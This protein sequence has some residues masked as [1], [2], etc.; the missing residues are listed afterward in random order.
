[1][2]FIDDVE[3]IL[4]YTNKEKR[5]MLFC[6]TMPERILRLAKDYMRGYQF[7]RAQKEQLTVSLTDQ[8]YFEV[9]QSDK[10][11]AL[12]RIIDSEVDF[13]GLIFCRTKIDVDSLSK[14]LS[15]RGYDAE[16]LHGDIS[17]YQ[18]ERILEKFKQQRINVLVA[19][20]VA[21]RGIDI[22]NLSHVINFSLPQDPESYVHRIGRTGRAGKEGTAITFV[23]PYEYRK[24][25]AIKRLT[26][27]DIRKEKIPAIEDIIR[28]KKTRI[29]NDIDAIIRSSAEGQYLDFA[30]EILTEVEPEKALAAIIKHAFGD[31]LSARSYSKIRDVSIDMKG[32]TRLFVARGRTDGMDPRKL[33]NML[34]QTAQVNPQKIRDVRIFDKFSF[35]T[36]P[37]E[38]AEVILHAF[39]KKKVSKRPI[40]ERAREKK[41]R[42][43]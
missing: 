8:I 34:K 17:Q 42:T 19:T 11:E 12:C 26:K 41:K 7:I 18:R 23:T 32:T 5:M 4:A 43:S 20:D 31:E 25:I 37:F 6:A 24:L 38:E 13:Y 21:A 10:L 14:K 30:Q 33:V 15:D 22:I 29:K 3:D 39:H 27:T 2:G 16:G 9:A 1:M 35:I 36:V 28:S 40:V